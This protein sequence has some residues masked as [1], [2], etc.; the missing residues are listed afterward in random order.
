MF[1]AMIALK[2]G[3]FHCGISNLS[4]VFLS[5]HRKTKNHFCKSYTRHPDDTY[6][7][8]ISTTHEFLLL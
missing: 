3:G 4:L 5:F 2:S 6:L 1:I 7:N 8:E